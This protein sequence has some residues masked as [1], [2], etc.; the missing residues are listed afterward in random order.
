MSDIP[1]K[2]DFATEEKKTQQYWEKEK[3]FA[4]NEDSDKPVFSIDTPPPTVSGKMH[5]GHSCSFTQQ[6][7]VARYK[8]MNGFEVFY[9]FGTDDNGLATEK[10]VQKQKKMSLRH[11]PRDEAIKTVL[12][13]LAE[14]R[15]VFIQDWK[16]IGMSCDFTIV[17]S[18]IDKN[19]QRIAQKTFLDMVKEGRAYQK[20]APVIWDTQFQSAIAQAELENIEKKTFF[21]DIVFKSEK[22]EDM[23]IA[24]TR[25]ELLAACVAVFAHPDD[26]RYQHLFGKNAISPLY[27][28]NVPI[29]PDEK[30]DPEKGTGLVMCC[31]FG[32]QTDIEW[33]K[34]HNLPLK[35]V[36]TPD[37]KMNEHSGKYSGMRIEDA[38]KEIIQDLK[39]AQLLVNQKEIV[40]AVN[41]GERSG[42]PVEI[43]NSKQ[44][45]IKYLDQRE[46]FLQSAEKLNWTPTHMKHR[47]DN[48]IKGLNWDWSISRQRHYGI[49]IPAWYDA[50]GNVYYADETQLP[51]DPSKDRPLSAPEGVEL[52][53]ESD[54][55]DTWFT[56]A[57]TPFLA[58]DAFKDK[59]IYKKLFPMSLRP[60]AHDIINFWLFYTMAKTQ[61]LHKVNPWEDVIISGFV[62]DPKGNK[63]S[64]SKG[65]TISPQEMSAKYSA[66]ALRY[67]AGGTKLGDDTPFMEKELVTGKKLITKLWNAAKF[68]HM[69]LEDFDGKQPEE[70][71]LLDKWMIAKTNEVVKKATD[72]FDKYEYS[73]AKFEIDQFFWT[74]LCDNYLELVKDRLYK[75]EIYGENA[76][77]SGQYTAKYVFT[78]VNKLLAPIVPYITETLY[79]TFF[80]EEQKSVHITH[81]PIQHELEADENIIAQGNSVV[82]FIATVRRQKAQDG[83]SLKTE[84]ESVVATPAAEFVESFKN[85]LADITGTIKADTVVIEPNE[86]AQKIFEK[87]VYKK[88]DEE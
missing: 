20:E 54:V 49:P 62:L 18:T 1:Q 34:K 44:W 22:G 40:H 31:T 38:R 57:S 39:E 52:T 78:T 79:Q 88:E 26:K 13:F 4:F 76:R 14:E 25:P 17:Y 51:V 33:Y 84:I 64:K 15:P 43:I 42:R 87:L 47:V 65:N 36:I 35:M 69:H 45:Y 66:D 67:W 81:W 73:K 6:D 75:P 85:A 50:Q 7:I 46:H 28:V 72:S 61:L 8:R 41:V 2:Y 32:D 55:F 24:T 5:I 82:E 70:L 74:T 59:P 48:W 21:N 68:V 29:L 53:P 80:L 3:I 58:T 11:V 10:L 60:Q 77:K 86:D 23:I 12:D 71:E 56:S 27:N 9:P 83:V 63:M 30:A 37:G 16:D 19:S